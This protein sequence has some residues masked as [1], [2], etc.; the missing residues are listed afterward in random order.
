MR[1]KVAYIEYRVAVALSDIKV[2]SLAVCFG[3]NAVESKRYSCPLILF[4]SS[5]IMS[6]KISH[7][8]VLINGVLLQIKTWRIYVSGGNTYSLLDILAAYTEKINT[9]S[10]IVKIILSAFFYLVTE[11]VF[12]ISMRYCLSDSVLYGLTLGFGRVYKVHITA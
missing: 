1:E 9:F 2:N 10:A 7:V 4:D 11:P 8:A 12:L 3:Y 5:V 6:L